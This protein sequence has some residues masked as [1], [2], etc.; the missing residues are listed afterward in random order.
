MDQMDLTQQQ[1]DL[2]K[3]TNDLRP[4]TVGQLRRIIRDIDDKVYVRIAVNPEFSSV[5]GRMGAYHGPA[6]AVNRIEFDEKI[7]QEE[8]PISANPNCIIIA[9]GLINPAGWEP[10]TDASYNLTTFVPPGETEG[11][12]TSD[13]PID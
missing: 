4:M 9:N 10:V 5:T 7:P 8:R 6:I 2:L 13:M 12:T 3:K 1:L 11:R